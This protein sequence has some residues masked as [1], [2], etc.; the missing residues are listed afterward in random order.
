MQRSGPFMLAVVSAAGLAVTH[1]RIA[2]V[3]AGFIALYILWVTIQ[4]VAG[5][6]RLSQVL[7]PFW[8]AG[9]VAVLTLGALSPWLVN[10]AH[11]FGTRF[12]GTS[13]GVSSGYYSLDTMVG[14]PLLEHPS[15]PLTFA[16]AFGGFVWVARRRDPLPLLPA[17]AWAILGLWSI[18]TSFP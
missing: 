10:L 14:R 16:L 17:I 8:S 2:M 18:L 15:L 3:Y 13:S 4:N 12:V 1:Y 6:H 5:R 7:R 9:L 11:N